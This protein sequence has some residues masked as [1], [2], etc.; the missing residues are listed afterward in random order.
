MKIPIVLADEPMAV[1]PVT[2]TARGAGKTQE[3]IQ[4]LSGIVQ[5]ISLDLLEKENN[6]RTA[7]TLS[8]AEV[9]AKNRIAQLNI[10]LA[11]RPDPDNHYNIW[12]EEYNK[13]RDNILS[14]VKN[15]ELLVKTKLLLDKIEVEEGIQARYQGHV[16]W[17]RRERG[18]I[19]NLLDEYSKKGEIDKGLALI[20]TG[21]D[22]GLFK[23]DEAEKI[24]LDFKDKVNLWM[25]KTE[26][27]LNP[28][29]AEEIINKYDIHPQQALIL[30]EK[31]ESLIA[32]R[33]AEEEKASVERI[34]QYLKDFTM[35]DY[36]SMFKLLRDV[37][38]LRERNISTKVANHVGNLLKSEYAMLEEERKNRYEDTAKHLYLRLGNN[39]L[40]LSDI[41]KTVQSDDL[42]WRLG[43]HFRQAL[44]SPPDVIT[45]PAEYNRIL[46]NIS[47]R[48]PKDEIHRDILSS[49]K[50]S[51][52]DKMAL[53]KE[54]FEAEDKVNGE[55]L[56]QAR[57]Y[58]KSQIIPARGI[59]SAIVRTPQE[60][61]DLFEAMK[62]LDA[63]LEE[64]RKAGR[65]IEG[66]DILRKAEEIAPLYQRSLAERMVDLQREMAKQGVLIKEKM[67]EEKRIKK[68]KKEEEE[69]IKRLTK[70]AEKYKTYEEVVIDYRKKNLTAAEAYWILKNKF[71]MED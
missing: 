57:D 6:I 63:V 60:E 24:K 28:E 31:A 11:N 4:R 33:Q 5:N 56:K 15:R 37:S 40:T 44:L 29:K 46:N 52:K 3:A 7:T 2:A 8:A 65:P 69:R 32:K 12:K 62:H 49:Q 14:K 22:N 23:E 30:S 42:S 36:P 26:I 70:K 39:T 47:L 19:A 27:S 18:K 16:L 64:A 1:R 53:G 41:D 21:I 58:L 51:R 45:D 10:D 43:E 50:L 54:V 61:K 25:A 67:E 48:K 38:F 34:Y 35:N 20:Q 71:N 55:W 17:Q 13:I 9:E 68:T 59:M 66:R